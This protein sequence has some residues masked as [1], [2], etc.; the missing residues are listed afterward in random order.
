MKR[1]NIKKYALMALTAM[2]VLTVGTSCKNDFE[3]PPIVI[4]EGGIGN[5]DWDNPLTAY[6]AQLGTEVEGK[7]TVWVT[8]YIVGWIDTSAGNKIM[9]T[10]PAEVDTNIAIAMT[11]DETDP[12]NCASVQLPSGAVRTALNLASHPDNQG[13]LVTIKGTTGDKYCGVYGVKSVSAYNWGD[14]GIYEEPIEP[15]V[16]V[17]QLYCNFDKSGEI[18]YYTDRGWTNAMERGALS[19]W[20]LRSFDNNNYATVSATNGTQFGGPYINWLITPPVDMDMMET[21]TLT[22]RTQGAYGHDDSKLEIFVLTS[23]DPSKGNPV[24]LEAEICTPN[25]DGASPVYSDWKQSGTVDLSQF[26]GIIYIGFK[27]TAEKGGMGYCSTYCVDDINIGD[28]PTEE[29]VDPSLAVTYRK[30]TSVTAGKEYIMVAAGKVAVPLS[31]NYGYLS[32]QDV[33]EE[34]G[35][36]KVNN[37]DL[38][39]TFVA[40]GTDFKIQQPDGRYLYLTGTYNSF[41]VSAEASEAGTTFSVAPQS[42]GTFIITNL[43]MNKTIQFS[44]SFNSF[45]CYSDKGGD[46]PTLYEKID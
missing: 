13:K 28:A 45:G 38:S 21:K 23:N 15:V 40:D 31:K 11:P 46:Y 44:Q 35:E 22:F 19:G 42:D 7:S 33:T 26:T 8:G 3:Q 5:G 34:N 4:P 18:G 16:P 41:N 2:S 12:D 32:V 14:K 36:I 24:Q 29:V 37:G 30:A 9:F 6:Q 10:T 25:P 27:Y 1:L 39:F 20:Y 17:G 43:L